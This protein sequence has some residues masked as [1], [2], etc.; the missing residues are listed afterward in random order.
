MKTVQRGLARPPTAASG[1]APSRSRRL[2]AALAGPALIVASSL[3]AM[4]AFAFANLLTNQ[5]PDI[6]SFWLPR[7]CLMGR[8][9]SAGHVPLWNPYEMAGSPFAA[10]PQSGW[11]Y[12]PW[13]LLSWL[14]PCGAGLR[15]FIVLQPILAGLGLYWFLRR[16]RLHRTAATA[17][18]LSLAMMIAASNVAISL[19]FAGTLAWTP[20][21][22]V[23]ASGFLSADRWARRLPWLALGAVAW[24]QVAS[25]HLSHGLVMCTAIV[26]AF[27]V[28]RSINEVRTGA[29]SVAPAALLALGFLAFLPLANLAILMPRF[30]LIPHTS[31]R[32]G[33]GA[34]GGTL[35]RIAGAEDRPIPTTGTW[36][37]WPFALASAP[38]AYAGAAILLLVPAA[39]RARARRYLVAAFAATGAVAYVLTLNAFVGAAWFRSLVFHVPFGDVYLHNPGRL[40]H[41]ALLVVSVLG[42]IGLQGFLDRRPSRR[43]A[44]WW[45]SG[46]AV[47]FLALPLSLGAHPWRFVVFV[48]G[49]VATVP[50]LIALVRGR[51]WAAAVL[52]LVLAADLLGGALWSSAYEGGTVYLGLERTGHPGLAPQPLRS[53]RAV[54]DRYLAPGRIARY[55]QAE[56][57]DE[58]RYVAWIPPAAYFNKGYLFTQD[59]EHWPALLLGRALLFRLHDALGYSP[60]QSP[61]YWSY[62][63]ATNR[64]PVFYN[65]SVLQLPSLEDVRLLGVR[66]LIAPRGITPPLRSFVVES[67]RGYELHEVAGWQPRASVVTDWTV[68]PGGVDALRAVLEPGFDPG[69]TAVVEGE[70]GS[71]AA[72]SPG[73]PGSPGSPGQATYREVWPE[74]LRIAARATAP[75]IVAVRNAWAQG[76]SAT[77]DG[78]PAPVVRTDYFLLGVPVPMGNHEIRLTYQDPMIGRGLKAS[79]FV[80]LAVVAAFA[81]P[82][83][84][85]RRR[86]RT[87]PEPP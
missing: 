48:I 70:E 45:T 50:V 39:L 9:L 26:T 49:A 55:L 65:A 79:A 42:A 80:W 77:V 75:S 23:G 52:P 63:R 57:R 69:T 29:R 16:E 76:W 85:G 31:L 11:L 73:L 36:S 78:R 41:L 5:H 84:A 71:A 22:L 81:A 68:V 25:A 19:P 15:A 67:E 86:R 4:R 44:A 13:M 38:G 6:L 60:I 35:A 28:A 47:L 56:G 51:R 82:G 46:A 54:V 37:G 7:S 40:R 14:L 61:R 20:L 62:V 33:Y 27:V 59:A 43:E 66:Y 74:D 1:A 30:S 58:A 83:L 72:A 3:V 32:G 64:L 2:A 18:G 34:L 21:V 17:G 87:A 10:D 12:L 53:P 8:S 24:G